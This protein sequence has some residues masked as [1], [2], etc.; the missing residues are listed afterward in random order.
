MRDGVGAHGELMDGVYRHQRWIYDATRKY[1]LLGRDRLLDDMRPAEEAHILEIACGTGRNLDRLDQRYP[2]RTL[3]GLDISEQMLTTARSK[4]GKR[5]RL[6]LGNA[7]NFDP[8]ALFGHA[9]FDHVFLSYCLS[10]IPDWRAAIS[11]GLMHLAPGGTLHIV[12]FGDQAG[13]PAPFKS[14]LYAWLEQFHVSP[15][16]ELSAV[17]RGL[18]VQ[19]EV[20]VE[21][22]DLYRGYAQFARLRRPLR[23][24][25]G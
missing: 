1:Y 6:A 17:L 13:L 19:Y 2:G 18:S 25:G 14:L 23:S 8:V 3:Y 22:R 7:C 21:H 16:T 9:A 11:E 24:D 20:E 10:M 12:D 4:L 15:R 5:A